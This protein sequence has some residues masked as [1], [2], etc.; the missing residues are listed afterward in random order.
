MQVR[1]TRDLRTFV[2]TQ[3]VRIR[4]RKLALLASFRASHDDVGVGNI[5]AFTK[6]SPSE[7]QSLPRSR[8]TTRHFHAVKAL[9]SLNVAASEETLTE[10]D[11][12]DAPL[13]PF[14]SRLGER[15]LS[16][17]QREQ[18]KHIRI[19]VPSVGKI[20]RVEHSLDIE[21]Q[22]TRRD[23]FT[24]VVSR[25]HTAQGV[26]QSN[27]QLKSLLSRKKQAAVSPSRATPARP[28]T[29]EGTMR[30]SSKLVT[31]QVQHGQVRDDASENV[32]FDLQGLEL[33]VLLKK[34]L[35]L[36]SLKYFV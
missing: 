16:I 8:S 29:V 22:P 7:S 14:T 32:A 17:L 15:P 30:H 5:S 25:P 21:H 24:G 27:E 31:A 36:V 13:P 3:I 11:D 20:H 34:Q 26:S 1:E 18:R 2:N 9:P 19:Q 33:E 10:V 35:Q 23:K 4:T 6:N 28:G 12:T